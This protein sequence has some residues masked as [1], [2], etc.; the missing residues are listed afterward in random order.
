MSFQ[1][2]FQNIGIVELNLHSVRYIL[3]C[4]FC[5]NMPRNPGSGTRAFFMVDIICTM[6]NEQKYHQ[7]TIS[8]GCTDKR[9]WEW[10]FLPTNTPLCVLSSQT[11]HYP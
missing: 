11:L 4:L 1:G 5:R 7:S 10:V 6:S 8:G 9:V 3:I 2:Q